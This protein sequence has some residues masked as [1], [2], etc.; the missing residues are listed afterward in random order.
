MTLVFKCDKCGEILN[1]SSTSIHWFFTGFPDDDIEG[2]PF[3][4][5]D[6]CE[7]CSPEVIQEILAIEK[8]V[9]EGK[10]Y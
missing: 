3:G 10:E 9:K 1:R 4:T 7:G 6:L 2:K 5:I 8:S